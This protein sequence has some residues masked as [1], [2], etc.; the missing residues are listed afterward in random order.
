[1]ATSSNSVFAGSYTS[2]NAFSTSQTRET[3]A[4]IGAGNGKEGIIILT[5]RK[6]ETT[7]RREYNS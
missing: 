3:L 6:N 7:G 5:R 2:P 1:M 4:A